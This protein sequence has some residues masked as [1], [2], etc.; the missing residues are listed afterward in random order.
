MNKIYS[1]MLSKNKEDIEIAKILVLEDLDTQKKLL[2]IAKY[3]GPRSQSNADDEFFLEIKKEVPNG[4]NLYFNI[5]KLGIIGDTK[6][7]FGRN[8]GNLKNLTPKGKYYKSAVKAI[9][10]LR[11]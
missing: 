1:L 9:R 7:V 8:W 6:E 11:Q 5:H 3:L 2:K 4:E 10:E